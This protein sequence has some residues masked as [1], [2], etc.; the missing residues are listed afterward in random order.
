MSDTPLGK[1]FLAMNKA[2]DSKVADMVGLRKYLEKA[3]YSA[4]YGS[5]AL[6]TKTARAFKKVNGISKKQKPK[7]QKKSDLFDLNYS[8]EQQMIQS[9]I[10]QFVQQNFRK[11]EEAANDKCKLPLDIVDQFDELGL[12]YY[13]IPEE[14]GG[15][16]I[17]KSTVTQMMITE[18]LAYGDLGIALGLLSPLGFLNAIVEWGT[19]EQQAKY[20]PAFLE[21]ENKLFA[22]I[23]I[24]EGQAL[25]DPNDL[26]CRAKKEGSSYVLNGVKTMV[27]LAKKAELFLIAANTDQGSQL[28][29]VESGK[30]GVKVQSDPMMGLRPAETGKIVLENVKVSKENMLGGGIDF[31]TF[32]QH[33]RLGWCALAVGTCQ[34]VLNYVIEYCNSRVA[35]GE[36]ITHRQAVAFL[37]ADMKI[38]L[39]GMRLLLQRAAAQ[40]E[41]GIDATKAT[42]LAVVSCQQYAMKIGNDGVQLLGGHGFVRDFPVE[43]WY[44][45]L[46][47]VALCYNGVHL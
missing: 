37:I 10:Q 13:S 30:N 5:V 21:E 11:Q 45:D 3:T 35:F 42:Y 36:P 9:A 46:R 28:F 19:A 31:Q 34:A 25:F 17:E 47:A 20:V 18:E 26:K 24:N 16:M 29:I 33:V 39:D 1:A 14:L 32:L 6:S 7:R 15:A 12:A 43:R 27:P 44:R 4:T 41:Q 23:A 38:E 40:I 2:L 22:S 8:E